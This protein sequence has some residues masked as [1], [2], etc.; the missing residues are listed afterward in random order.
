M[1][2]ARTPATLE[3]TFS[4]AGGHAPRDRALAGTSIGHRIKHLGAAEARA[5]RMIVG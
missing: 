5:Y 4:T 2:D 1:P 3:F